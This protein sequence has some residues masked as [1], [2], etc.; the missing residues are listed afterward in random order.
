[1]QTAAREVL[2]GGIGISMTRELSLKI[3]EGGRRGPWGP[4]MIAK[5]W[6]KISESS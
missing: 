3:G 5:F 4:L 2:K 6:L 1:M